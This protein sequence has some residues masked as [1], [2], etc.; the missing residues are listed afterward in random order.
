[1]K[2]SMNNRIIAFAVMAAMSFSAAIPAITNDDK[3][4]VRTELKF[5]GHIDNQPVFQL[6]LDNA[7]AQEFT[8][9]I[10]DQYNNV[11]Y[12]F[13]SNDGNFNKKFLLNTDEIG[14]DMLRF[15][16]TTGKNKPVVYE[17]NRN[18]RLVQEV[19][20]NKVQ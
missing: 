14:D 3:S 2:N 19:V 17:V 9:V 7:T 4:N 1:M 15:E 16:I 12:R 13:S 11:L 18:S 10:R 20:V 6:K 5:V 8:V